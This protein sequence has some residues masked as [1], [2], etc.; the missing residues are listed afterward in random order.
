M[1]YRV[2]QYKKRNDRTL[3]VENKTRN[4][5]EKKSKRQRLIGNNANLKATLY[6]NVVR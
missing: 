1:L 2:L 6:R 5:G 4:R 3:I